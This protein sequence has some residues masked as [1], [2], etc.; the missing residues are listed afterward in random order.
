MCEHNRGSLIADA[1]D[2]RF[3]HIL[4]AA[5]SIRCCSLLL[6]PAVYLDDHLELP[7]LLPLGLW[8]AAQLPLIAALPLLHLPLHPGPAEHQR[9]QGTRPKGCGRCQRQRLPSTEPPSAPRAHS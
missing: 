9:K 3:R 8:A 2:V 1:A 7:T 6:Q 4:Y 5:V